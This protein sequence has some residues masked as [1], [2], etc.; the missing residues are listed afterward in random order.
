[1]SANVALSRRAFTRGLALFGLGSAPAL[2]QGFAGLGESASGYAAITPGKTFSFPAD[3]GPHPAYRIEWWYLTTNLTDAGG[4]AYGAQW[5][6]FRLAMAPGGDDEGWA[7]Q[8]IWMAHAAVTRADSHR[9]S[10]TFARGGVG[11]AGVEARPFHA[12]IDSWQMRGSERTDPNTISPLEL[13]ASAKDFSYALRLEADRPLVLQGDGGYSRKS[14]REQASYYYSQPFFKAS[15]RLTIDDSPVD[16][17]GQAWMDREWSSQPL[18]P[19]QPGWDWFALH[20]KTGEKLMLYRMR[21]KDGN[22]YASGNWIMPD[23]K[24]RQLKAS[25]I[26]M[27]PHDPVEIEG[28]KRPVRWQVSIPSLSLSIETAPVNPRSWMGTSTPY[29][30]GPIGFHGSHTGVGYLEMTGY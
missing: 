5:T 6:L 10:E 30:E 26:A 20:V 12:W 13:T 8:Q 7:S 9:T 18:A 29:W 25:D 23:G 17:T 2:A 15:G 21:E 3:H 16:V 24:A 4:T 19:D 27:T 1:M 28:R 11:Q 22:D 14:L